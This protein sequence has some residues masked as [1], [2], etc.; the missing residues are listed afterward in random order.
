MFDESEFSARRERA[1]VLAQAQ[2]AAWKQTRLCFLAAVPVV[3]AAFIEVFGIP[4]NW[5]Y[6]PVQVRDLIALL[7]L[8]VTVS[9]TMVLTLWNRLAWL[10]VLAF[11]VVMLTAIFGVVSMTFSGSDFIRP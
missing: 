5:F 4:R 2:Q 10:Y 11:A 1:Q 6:A 9:W 7:M 3:I 8:V